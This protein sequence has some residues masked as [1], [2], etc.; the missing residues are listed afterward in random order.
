MHSAGLRGSDFR[1]TWRGSR[2]SHSQFFASFSPDHR[3]AVIAPTGLDGVAATTLIMA[4]VTAFY[5]HYRADGKRSIAYPSF[6][7]FQ[8]V[9]P[10]ADYCMLDIWPYHRNVYFADDQFLVATIAARNIDVLLMPEG[11]AID[12]SDSGVSRCFTYSD[13]EELDH[14]DLAVEVDSRL[15]RDYV[16]AVVGSRPA[17]GHPRCREQE[18]QFRQFYHEVDLRGENSLGG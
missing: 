4:Y 8:H 13:G 12:L 11:Y 6:F 3:L 17:D 14:C 9:L 5:D 7:T 1:L 16:E 2:I 15:L 18:G 10:C